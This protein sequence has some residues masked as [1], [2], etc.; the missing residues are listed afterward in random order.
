MFC[1]V[2]LFS[3]FQFSCGCRNKMWS[4]LAQMPANYGLEKHVS[5]AHLVWFQ[6]ST[7]CPLLLLNITCLFAS[8]GFTHGGSLME[9]WKFPPSDVGLNHVTYISSNHQSVL[10][11]SNNTVKNKFSHD[12]I[13]KF[14][15]FTLVYFTS[16]KSY[17]SYV[18]TFRM[19]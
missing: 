14:Q 5:L 17:A 13:K 10:A 2:C 3:V 11:N 9:V 12:D 19:P 1:F 4:Y 7:N 6:E 18:V 8:T 16:L 15:I